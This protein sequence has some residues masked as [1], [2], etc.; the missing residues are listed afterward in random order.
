MDAESFLEFASQVTKLKMYPYFDVAHSVLC[1]LHVR[2]DLGPGKTSTSVFHDISSRLRFY[3]GLTFRRSTGLFSQAPHIMLVVNDVGRL[4]RWYAECC[5]TRWTSSST[6]QEQ[7]TACDR[8]SSLVIEFGL[9]FGYSMV[10]LYYC[11]PQVFSILHTVWYW[12]QC[13]K[14]STREVGVFCYER[15]LPVCMNNH[16]HITL[17]RLSCFCAESWFYVIHFQLQK[18]PWWCVAC[19]QT[20]SQ[21][22][23]HND[24]S[25]YS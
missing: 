12:I 8:Y 4:C 1:A 25:W 6:A 2:D 3:L 5:I 18:S 21:C 15:D 19:C 22:I 20:L 7:P 16:H 13:F 24:Y 17:L 9:I 23:H 11:F 10:S 14:V